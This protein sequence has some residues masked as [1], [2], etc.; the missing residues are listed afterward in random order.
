MTFDLTKAQK[1]TNDGIYMLAAGCT[2]SFNWDAF[3]ENIIEKARMFPDAIS[4]I[5][6]LTSELTKAHKAL[7]KERAK[8]I[9]KSNPCPQRTRHEWCDAINHFCEVSLDECYE[10]DR[11]IDLAKEELKAE[12]FEIDDQVPVK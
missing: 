2:G 12:G 3:S 9:M 11:M 4:E 6:R 7:V 10:K 1:L 8:D 5:E